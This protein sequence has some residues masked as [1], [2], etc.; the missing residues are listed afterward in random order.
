MIIVDYV[1]NLALDA[2]KNHFKC[3]LDEQKIKTALTDYMKRQRNYNEAC[4][5]AEEIDF[6]GL[7]DYVCTN[8]LDDVSI[9]A[10][11]PDKRVRTRIREQIIDKAVAYSQAETDEAK[12]K[13]ATSI[14]MET[15]LF[16]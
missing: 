14:S 16:T 7:M 6:Q 3:K 5:L 13:V 12:K 10:F 2:G 9:R 1:G 11:H 15:A 4:S 8:F